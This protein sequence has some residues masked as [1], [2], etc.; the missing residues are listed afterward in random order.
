MPTASDYF[1][2]R[3]NIFVLWDF[4]KEIVGTIG[5]SKAL[6]LKMMTAPP[7]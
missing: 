1:K 5:A 7:R 4:T 6:S 2:P 3:A